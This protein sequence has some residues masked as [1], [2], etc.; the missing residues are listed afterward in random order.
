MQL[1]RQSRN[2]DIQAS[3]FWIKRQTYNY[4]CKTKEATVKIKQRHIK[5]GIAW[6]LLATLL[7][8]SLAK[9]FHSH[10]GHHCACIQMDSD[11]H[12]QD[13]DCQ[14]PICNF[15]LSPFIESEHTEILPTEILLSNI[16][17]PLVDIFSPSAIRAYSL[18][19]PPATI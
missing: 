3:L 14:C 10:D 13:D 12:S 17:L 5:I 4:I 2:N 6:L 18:R 19:G 9:A 1:F 11:N 8:L 7:Q 15:I 16:S